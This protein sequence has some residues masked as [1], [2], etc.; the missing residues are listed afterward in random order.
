MGIGAAGVHYRMLL[1]RFLRDSED[2]DVTPMTT[3]KREHTTFKQASHDAKIQLPVSANCRVQKNSGCLNCSKE[4]CRLLRWQDRRIDKMSHPVRTTG[5][6]QPGE[7]LRCRSLRRQRQEA[8]NK[9]REP[10]GLDMTG[11]YS[12]K[13]RSLSTARS[14]AMGSSTHIRLAPQQPCCGMPLLRS[15]L[16]QR[17]TFCARSSSRTG[18]PGRNRTARGRSSVK[19]LTTAQSRVGMLHCEEENG[20]NTNPS[21]LVQASQQATPRRRSYATSSDATLDPRR[22]PLAQAQSTERRAQGQRKTPRELVRR[23]LTK[24]HVTLNQKLQGIV[25]ARRVK[26]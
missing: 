10:G 14:S 1:S 8:S 21:G 5:L 26:Q 6:Q 12:S 18:C 22:T 17:T 7:R 13:E 23:R 15:S 20:R 16:R 24:T 4:I 25:G 11:V 2:T 9:R 19:K 3:S